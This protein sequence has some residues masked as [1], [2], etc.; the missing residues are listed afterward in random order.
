M[1]TGL[2]AL[3][4]FTIMAQSNDTVNAELGIEGR[5]VGETIFNSM[6]ANGRGTIHMG[7]IEE[8]RASVFSGMDYDTNGKVTYTEFSSW[9]PGFARVAEAEGRSDAYTTASKIIFAFWDRN[10]DGDLTQ[11]EMRRALSSDV[12]R[13]D[14]DN[15][16]LLTRMEFIQEFPLM[17]AMRAAI[18]SDRKCFT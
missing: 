9:D 3:A 8:Y 13:A 16:G 11:P 14:L 10:G 2:L 7:D 1:L 17:V 18:R 4:P 15:D 6:D 5:A 12:R